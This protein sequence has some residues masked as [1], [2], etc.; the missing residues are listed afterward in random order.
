[1]STANCAN[2]INVLNSILA[3]TLKNFKKDVDALMEKGDKKEIAIMHVIQKYI[4]ESKKILF[5]GDNYSEEWHH[6]AERRGL[7]NVRTTP[8]ALDALVTD[9]AN[10]YL[11]AIKCIH[12]AKLKHATR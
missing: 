7:P 8:L 3:E 4:A 12:I 9:K 2:A 5:E 10:I 1:M 6:E 11:K